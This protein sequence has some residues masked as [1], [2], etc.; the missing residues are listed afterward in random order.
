MKFNITP[1]LCIGQ[2]AVMV[3]ILP[4]RDS[5]MTVRFYVCAILFNDVRKFIKDINTLYGD[6]QAGLNLDSPAPLTSFRQDDAEPGV[7]RG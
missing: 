7:G 2:R 1:E 6:Y 3:Q 4:R 5:G